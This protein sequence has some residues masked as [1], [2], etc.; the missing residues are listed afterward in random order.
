MEIMMSDIRATGA[1]VKMHDDD[2]GTERVIA[3]VRARIG[4]AP[5]P[6]WMRASHGIEAVDFSSWRVPVFFAAAASI[7]VG[8]YLGAFR[9]PAPPRVP[10]P[11]TI[12]T[13]IGIPAPIALWMDA[14]IPPS[15]EALIAMR[16][17]P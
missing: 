11:T 10:T 9:E 2:D 6:Q 17:S 12:A 4:A 13:S 3:S 16:R 1:P 7:T 5:P 14:R 15:N 8:V